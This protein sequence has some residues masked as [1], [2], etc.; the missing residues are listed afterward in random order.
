MEESKD[1]TS[2]SGSCDKMIG[3]IIEEAEGNDRTAPQQLHCRAV[4]ATSAVDL[5]SGETG[6]EL[7]R[8]LGSGVINPSKDETVQ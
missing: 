1:K 5:D 7:F 3:K 2:S 4:N 8:H 6:S